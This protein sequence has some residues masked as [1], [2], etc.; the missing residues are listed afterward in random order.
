VREAGG[1][2]TDSEGGER[3]LETGALLAATPALMQPLAK[4][5]QAAAR[6]EPQAFRQ[7]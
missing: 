3:M 6:A 7:G 5:V 4:L 2:V 1:A